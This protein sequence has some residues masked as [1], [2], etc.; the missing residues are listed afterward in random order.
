MERE[1]KEYTCPICVE[2]EKQAK[3]ERELDRWMESFV[4]MIIIYD[5]TSDLLAL[6]DETSSRKKI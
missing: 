1:G 4:C 3:A 2:K 5:N 6:V